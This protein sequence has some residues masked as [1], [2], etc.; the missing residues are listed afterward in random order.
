M[1]IELADRVLNGEVVG[2]QRAQQI[3][4]QETAAGNQAE[5]AEQT[6]MPENGS[7]SAADRTQLGEWLACGAP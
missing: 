6:E 7:V 4:E 3:Y 1:T 5:L 2:K